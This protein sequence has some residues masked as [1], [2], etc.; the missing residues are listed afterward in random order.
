MKVGG[1]TEWYDAREGALRGG[2]APQLREKLCGLRRGL[3][4]PRMCPIAC[5]SG[6]QYVPF[7]HTYLCILRCSE[8]E[9]R[10]SKIRGSSHSWQAWRGK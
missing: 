1:G 7:T 10:V 9:E 5:C 2:E 3:Y 8:K 4:P 6:I